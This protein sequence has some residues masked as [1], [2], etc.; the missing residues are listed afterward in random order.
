MDALFIGHAYI[1]VTMLADEMP[2]GDEKMVARDYA[3]SFGGNAVTAGFACAKLGH[4]VHIL[5]TQARD[6]LGHMFAEMADAHGV[7]LHPRKVARSS[8]SFVLPN[9]GKRAILRARDDAYLQS[10]LRLDISD[11]RVLHLDGHMADAALHY[12]QAA[13]ER[14]VLVSL[15]GGALRPGIEALF[16]FVDVAVV[17]KQLCQQMSFTELEMLAWLKSKGC[18]IGAVTVGEKGTFWYSED[19]VAQHLPALHVPPERVVDTSGAGDVFH[20]A[21]C[22]SYLERPDAPW[23]DHFEFARAASAHKVQ[24][25]GNEAG[26]P[27]RA[28][29]ARAREEFGGNAVSGVEI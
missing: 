27:T 20:G 18:R 14:G 3:V 7:R 15:D 10:F 21:Y 17:S 25:L 2:A 19:G 5:T 8:L 11:A 29:I 6:W 4:D 16:D 9:D 22:A 1:D 23:R 28:D 24:H 13:R 26:L 12:T